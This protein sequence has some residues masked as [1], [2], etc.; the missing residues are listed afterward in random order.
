MTI[1][2]KLEELFEKH[3]LSL[4]KVNLIVTDGALAM[5]SKSRGLVSRIKNVPPKMYAPHCLIHQSVLCT[6]LS[7]D[8]KEVID[9]TMKIIN[10]IRGNSSTQHRL[11]R[12]FVLES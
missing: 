1:F 6:K 7:G 12:K 2:G 11:F 4:E 9:K 3:G 5:V 10:F 8:L